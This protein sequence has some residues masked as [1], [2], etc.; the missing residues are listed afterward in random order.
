[1]LHTKYQGSMPCG[2]S[3]SLTQ[4]FTSPQQLRSYR[5]R[6]LGFKPHPKGWW[7]EKYYKAFQKNLCRIRDSNSRR[8]MTQDQQSEALTAR[9]PGHRYIDLV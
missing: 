1:M 2:F 5:R 3:L 8:L 4:G 9:P 7:G 6:D